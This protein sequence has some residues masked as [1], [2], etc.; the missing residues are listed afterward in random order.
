MSVINIIKLNLLFWVLLLTEVLFSVY[1]LTGQLAAAIARTEAYPAWTIGLYAALVGV[2]ASVPCYYRSGVSKVYA[3]AM[4][5]A[6]AALIGGLFWATQA[7]GF[8]SYAL[9]IANA[10]DKNVAPWLMGS[11]GAAYMGVTIA[12]IA[13]I[14]SFARGRR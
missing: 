5:V 4:T 6:S 8:W 11:F 1:Y 10:A 13:L 12:L 7:F 3:A 9:A 14:I 2:V